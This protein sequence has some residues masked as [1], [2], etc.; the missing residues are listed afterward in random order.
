MPPGR[1]VMKRRK[2]MKQMKFGVILLALLLAA[3]AMVPMVSAGGQ[4]MSP[5]KEKTS[6]NQNM[7]PADLLPYAT[8]A[9]YG[10]SS[11]Q[12]N[13]Q[14]SVY[15]S[16]EIGNMINI[17]YQKFYIQNLAT[18]TTAGV[19]YDSTPSGWS[20][21]MGTWSKAGYVL[22]HDTFSSSWGVEFTQS[23][24]Y[25]VVASVVGIG[26]VPNAQSRMVISVP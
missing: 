11:A 18:G 6:V 25:E 5:V 9:V 16:G 12:R 22:G 7:T 15:T 23:G 8:I 21:Y 2:K 4:S 26:T 24:M 14:V 1:S 17:Y 20:Q 3:M 10:P 19:R 13:H